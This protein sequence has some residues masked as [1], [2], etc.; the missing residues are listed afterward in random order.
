[1]C[2]DALVVPPLFFFFFNNHSSPLQNIEIIKEVL[3]FGHA[4][5]EVK[6]HNLMLCWPM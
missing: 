2:T 1:M 6:R 5:A 4:R 3:L